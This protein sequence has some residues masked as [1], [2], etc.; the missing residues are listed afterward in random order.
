MIFRKVET[1]WYN[2]TIE[3]IVALPFLSGKAT[4][5]LDITSSNSASIHVFR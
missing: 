2:L 1:L 3:I 5:N 4:Q